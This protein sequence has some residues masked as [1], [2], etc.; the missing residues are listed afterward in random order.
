M[1]RNIYDKNICVL[2][3]SGDLAADCGL[4][5]QIRSCPMPYKVT[6]KRI[7]NLYG[8]INSFDPAAP[9]G[10]APMAKADTS[11][12]DLYKALGL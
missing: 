4:F 11:C 7:S 12:A 6:V 1:A 8:Q 3:Q 9:R 2:T 5:R 10:E